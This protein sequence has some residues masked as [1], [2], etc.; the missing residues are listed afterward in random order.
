MSYSEFDE[1]GNYLLTVKD[2]WWHNTFVGRKGRIVDGDGNVT[3]NFKFADPKNDVKDLKD[4]T[5]NRVQFVQESEIIS[6]LSKGGA[7]TK[8]NKTYNNDVTYRYDYVK[9]EG[10]GGGKL[11]FSVT[12]IPYQYPAENVSQTLFLVDGVAHNHFNFGNFMFGA[13]GEALSLA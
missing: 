2:N 3:Q 5:I 13:A 11:D 1:S 6:M 8:E 9:E 4:G 12:G 7:F 10:Q